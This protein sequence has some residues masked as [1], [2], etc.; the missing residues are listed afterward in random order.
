MASQLLPLLSRGDV[1]QRVEWILLD[2]HSLLLQRQ[3]AAESRDVQAI[4]TACER[5]SAIIRRV[6]LPATDE[7]LELQLK[8]FACSR[9]H[10][11]LSRISSN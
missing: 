5:L 8:V 6:S 7:L 11:S 3:L 10:H 1:F 9:V 2:V 4:A